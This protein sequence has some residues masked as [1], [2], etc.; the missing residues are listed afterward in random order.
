MTKLESDGVINV[1]FAQA[2][3]LLPYMEKDIIALDKAVSEYWKNYLKF[4][5]KF[6]SLFH[7]CDTYQPNR[8][9]PLNQA[10]GNLELTPL[11]RLFTV[12]TAEEPF[13]T[14]LR[15]VQQQNEIIHTCYDILN[16]CV[17]HFTRN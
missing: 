17:N 10:A 14:S 7:S 1:D 12:I 8:N 6:A 9:H 15:R 2:A 5:V 13:E 3:D 11:I 4:K 16:T